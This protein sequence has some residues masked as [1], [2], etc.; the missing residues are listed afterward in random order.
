MTIQTFYPYRKKGVTFARP[1]Q[2]GESLEGISISP[3]DKPENG[4][5]IATNPNNPSD[6][7]YISEEYFIANFIKANNGSCLTVDDE[8]TLAHTP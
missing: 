2:P 7:W 5:F 4:G 3:E 8:T 1:Y 6:K